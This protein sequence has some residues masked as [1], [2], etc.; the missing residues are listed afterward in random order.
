MTNTEQKVVGIIDQYLEGAIT[1]EECVRATVVAAVSEFA[2]APV[3]KSE[4]KV[5]MRIEIDVA[6]KF[7]PSG[8][9]IVDFLASAIDELQKVRAAVEASNHRHLDVAAASLDLRLVEV[10]GTY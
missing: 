10:V 9:S 3:E 2:T 6:G 5:G 4:G 1:L 8:E 7:N